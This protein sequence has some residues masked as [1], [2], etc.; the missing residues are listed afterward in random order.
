MV[1]RNTTAETTPGEIDALAATVKIRSDVPPLRANRLDRRVTTGPTAFDEAMRETLNTGRFASMDANASVVQDLRLRLARSARYLSQQDEKKLKKQ[2]GS[3]PYAY[4]VTIVITD[5][6]YPLE[7][8]RSKLAEGG[9]KGNITDPRLTAYMK[10]KGPDDP[11]VFWFQMHLPEVKGQR[12]QNEAAAQGAASKLGGV[13]CGSPR[14]YGGTAYYAANGDRPN[15]WATG[16]GRSPLACLW[17]VYPIYR[18]PV[19]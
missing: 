6:R 19:T 17:T 15:P 10:E 5:P 4:A 8:S 3:E 2:L 9:V 18:T 1:A 11:V 7:D 12:L 14:R 16:T 13:A